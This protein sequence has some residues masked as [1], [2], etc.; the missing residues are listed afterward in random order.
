MKVLVTGG[1]DYADRTRVFAELN[2]LLRLHG[3]FTVV[4]GDCE[5]GAD[6]F[7]HAWVEASK[8]IGRDIGERRF[9][10][11]WY[12]M[13]R[14][15]KSAGPRRNQEMVE[16]GADLCLAFPGGRGTADCVRRARKAGIPVV[17]VR[18]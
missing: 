18:Q 14:L 13:G 1:R 9:P 6:S 8:S 2:K 16:F 10:A 4:H 11:D 17:E 12:P 15:D 3:L 5:T 7:A